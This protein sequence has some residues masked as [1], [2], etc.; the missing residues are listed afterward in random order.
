MASHVLP[1]CQMSRAFAEPN[2]VILKHEPV[3]ICINSNR[4]SKYQI[5]LMATLQHLLVNRYRY[6]SRCRS[7]V[8][9][10]EAALI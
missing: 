8:P 10:L 9:Y 6:A 1:V 5:S 7:I 2:Y 3:I 4:E